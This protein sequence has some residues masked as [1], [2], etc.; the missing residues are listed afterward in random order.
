MTKQEEFAIMTV[1]ACKSDIKKM[2]ELLKKRKE[3]IEQEE[4]FKKYG[5]R[6]GNGK[7]TRWKLEYH[8]KTIRKT[9]AFDMV[10]YIRTNLESNEKDFCEVFDLWLKKM[11]DE[12]TISKLTA[13][14]Y[15]QD[16]RAYIK[17]TD[18]AKR[19]L[20]ELDEDSVAD[21]LESFKGRD[22]TKK[23]FGG[24]KTIMRGV[25]R[26]AKRKKYTK[27][28]FVNALEIA[29]LPAKSFKGVKREEQVYLEQEAKQII[30]FCL[31]EPIN[32]KVKNCEMKRLG[33]AL[34]FV[35][36]LRRG[37]LATLKLE[38]VQGKEFQ[39]IRVARSEHREPLEAGGNRYYVGETKT[40]NSER[41]VYLSKSASQILKRICD[42]KH[43]T[44]YLF[45][46]DG[47]WMKG[48]NFDKELNRI[49]KALGIKFRSM[50]KIRKTYATT[51]INNGVEASTTVSL[52]GHADY[53]TTLK[54][55]HFDNMDSKQKIEA[56]NRVFG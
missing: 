41:I 35:T 3:E 21:F 31:N 51:L 26:Y 56:V 30:E 15:E 27:V 39:A 37:E 55:Y 28:S 45:E 9:S 10:D 2:E 1:D 5:V 4:L 11:V 48:H 23:R 20:S 36:G 29:E 7:D 46:Q 54:S 44:E 49:C 17:E 43:E 12:N 8:S 42:L 22:I 6:R 32:D 24:I 14:R 50:H 19:P 13:K 33:I 16:Y 53:S 47:D 34:C 25:F 52:M 38:D 40:E 18:F